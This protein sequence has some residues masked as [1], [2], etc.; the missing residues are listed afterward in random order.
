MKDK[1]VLIIGGGTGIGKKTAFLCAQNGAKTVIL[2][3]LYSEEVQEVAEKID[4]L[5]CSAMAMQ[6]DV[7][8]PESVDHCLKTIKDQYGCIDILINTAGVCLNTPFNKISPQEWDWVLR[9]NTFGTFYS[10]QKVIELMVENGIKGSIV[11]VSSIAAK[12]GAG[13][14]GA[15]YAASKAAIINLTISAATYAARYGIRVNAVAPGPIVT[16]MTAEW[17]KTMCAKLLKTIPLGRTFGK[18]E[19]VA[20]AIVF[21]AGSK[22]KYISGEI[23]D[24]NGGAYMD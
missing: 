6:V 17:D 21:L 5:G 4:Q 11:N 8:K 10:N 15:H 7:T 22:A 18:V 19:D 2:G 23:L 20:E 12:T 14:V 9:T 16:D 3:G 24:V 1:I 13:A